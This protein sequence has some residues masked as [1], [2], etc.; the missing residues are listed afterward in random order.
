MRI[1][2]IDPGPRESGVVVYDAEGQEDGN[3]DD[4]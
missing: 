2:A 1:L 3:A 4:A